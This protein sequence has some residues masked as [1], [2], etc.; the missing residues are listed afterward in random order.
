MP[1]QVTPGQPGQSLLTVKLAGGRPQ[2]LRGRYEAVLAVAEG[3]AYQAPAQRGG[4]KEVDQGLA[5]RRHR[6]PGQLVTQLGARQRPSVGY[7]REDH[8][9]ASVRVVRGQALLAQTAGIACCQLWSGQRRQPPVVV[10]GD[11]VKGAPVEPCDQQC[12]ALGQG[13]VDVLA[14]DPRAP[15]PY[16]QACPAHVL[17]L[18]RQQALD[19]R[20][21]VPGFR[22]AKPL[23]SQPPGQ[24]QPVVGHGHRADWSSASTKRASLFGATRV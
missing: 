10:G 2:P 7:G 22:P 11:Q 18:D 6:G 24:G 19:D 13:V 1:D 4:N 12:P 15:G 9:D 5:S 21:G 16:G 23:G 14:V 17:G 8:C 20:L 3:A